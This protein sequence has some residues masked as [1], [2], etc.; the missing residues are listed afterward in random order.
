M[1]S[2]ITF[3]KAARRTDVEV[4]RKEVRAALQAQRIFTVPS[5]ETDVSN[6]VHVP[7]TRVGFL[8]AHVRPFIRAR[9]V[10]S[11][12]SPSALV[13][14]MGFAVAIWYAQ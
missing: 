1:K 11:S 4:R 14:I 12:P 6:T 9:R 5:R 7:A 13:L 10:S 3:T 2:D 8:S